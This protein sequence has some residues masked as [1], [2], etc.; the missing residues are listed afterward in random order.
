MKLLAA[1]VT[2]ALTTFALATPA[3]SRPLIIEDSAP[4]ENPDP[5]RYPQFGFDVATNGQ[6]AFVAASD[7][8][9]FSD[10]LNY[11]VLL[12]RRV[13]GQWTLQREL[14]HSTTSNEYFYPMELVMQGNLAA[15]GMAGGVTAYHLVGGDWVKGQ[16]PGGGPSDYLRIDG[17]RIL[18]SEGGWDA[19]VA[20]QNSSG[21]WS[22]T[23]LQGQP[24]G[25]DDEFWG[26]PIDILG[27][28]VILGTPYTF[29]LED[30]EIPI[31]AR[32]ASQGWSLYTK[33]H[34]PQGVYRLGAAV[35]LNGDDAIVEGAGGPYVW[36]AP[37]FSEPVG[38]IQAIDSAMPQNSEAGIETS[39]GLV[40]YRRDSV[41]LGNVVHVFRADAQ[42][43][44]QEV[45]TLVARNGDALRNDMSFGG[46]TVMVGSPQRVHVFVLPANLATPAPRYDNFE[47]GAG[48]W[49]PSASARF[50]VAGNTANHVY[51]QSS[52]VGDARA[53][54]D[55]S[56]T[57]QGIEADIRATEFSGSD[58]WFG[59]I[60]RYRDEQNFFYVTL[61]SSGTVQL[62][63]V[64]NGAV[65]ELARAPL[66]VTT[67]RTY[68]VRLESF[69]H[70]HRVYVDGQLLLDVDVAGAVEAGS[71]G[72][73]MYRTRADFDNVIV[74]PGPRGT[75]Y[76][77]D[78]S[79]TSLGGWSQ[80]GTGQWSVRSGALAQDSIGGDARFAIGTSTG[81][82]VVQARVRPTAYAAP[83][84]TQERWTG[85]F[86]RFKDPQ[87]F[88][89]LSLRS[90]NTV[91]LR[92]VVNG[93]I[94]TLAS[95]PF[96]VV[97]GKPHL[98]RLE[99]TGTQLRAYVGGVQRLQA[100]DGALAEGSGG[101]VTFKAAATFDDY[102]AY[103]P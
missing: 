92:K 29:D 12:Y 34:T 60:T 58:R 61:R 24:R 63:R 87:N 32:S 46:N 16:A 15:I 52:V 73:A 13:N 75:I 67:N 71:S 62:R 101:V 9:G 64:R 2:C 33:L 50:A 19:Y 11:Y 59:L 48:A 38:R 57:H 6:Y 30:Q 7:A 5:A 72:I 102:I 23:F 37:Y 76:R 47:N 55:N 20:Q 82:Q 26:G 70:T 4:I 51:R 53:L 100:S 89:Y 68:R 96:S 21:T 14:A 40:L 90:G 31:Y 3:H 86:A 41:D 45:A 83:S 17:G 98:L 88:Y 25:Y 1:L 10:V 56:W 84:G 42:L 80:T 49:T 65:S 69:G 54:L 93:A 94:T 103:Q 35:G 97:L 8:S 39:G 95:A 44:Y 66:S 81:D 91:S 78:F 85:V 27:D 18:M 22:K 74:S 28:R 36:R 79:S 43:R 99:V 77:S